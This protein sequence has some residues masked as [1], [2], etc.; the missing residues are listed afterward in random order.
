MKAQTDFETYLRKE[1]LA[2]HTI[3]C[4]TTT[5]KFYLSHY[6][7]VSRENLLAYKGYL[8]ECC[9]PKTVN[10]RI[11]AMNKYL[12]F[13]KKEGMHVKNIKVQEKIF[14]E[15]VISN[16][17]YQ[18]LKDKLK[19]DGNTKWYFIVWYLA[20]TGAR[21]SELTK[22]RIEDVKKGYTDSYTKGGKIRRIYIP[23]QL[24]EET[25]QWLKERGDSSGLLF[26]NRFG[27]AITTRGIG[28]QLKNYAKKYG[29]NP[30]MVYPHSFR[31]RYAKNFLL[32]HN[33]IALLADL[34][35]HESTETTRIYLRK[36]ANEQ[37]ALIDKIIDW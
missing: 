5:V 28:Q 1:D 35:G 21:V 15:N 36:T 24:R 32:R 12:I 3:S 22:I 9:K 17:D 19:E 30:E 26:I 23:L 4:Y 7:T 10:A 37:R 6:E 25:L 31:H 29:L 2:E 27:K 13:L 18:Y 8:I 33:D 20:A 34:M 16:E 11:Q 14:L